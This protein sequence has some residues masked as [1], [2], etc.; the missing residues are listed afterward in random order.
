ML[1]EV[2]TRKDLTKNVESGLGPQARA[3]PISPADEE[4][5]LG[6]SALQSQQPRRWLDHSVAYK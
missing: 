1:A 4:T 5:C 3:L 6:R 2:G